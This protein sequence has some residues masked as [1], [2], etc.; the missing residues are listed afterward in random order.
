MS[1]L[2]QLEKI[3]QD[4]Q[5]FIRPEIEAT[6]F[7]ANLGLSWSYFV[8]APTDRHSGDPLCKALYKQKLRD[9]SCST[10]FTSQTLSRARAGG[11]TATQR[12]TFNS[13]IAEPERNSNLLV[14]NPGPNC[15]DHIWNANGKFH[16]LLH[17]P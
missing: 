1:Q 5:P 8:L 16:F 17:N 9:S 12:W 7:K 6:D 13:L 10:E 14:C 3:K 2:T 11:Q 4:T 15:P